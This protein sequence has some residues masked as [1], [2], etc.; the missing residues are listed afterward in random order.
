MSFQSTPSRGYCSHVAS[1][2]TK[3]Q[4]SHEYYYLDSLKKK[5][6]V[7]TLYSNRIQE[8][9]YQKLYLFSVDSCI[10]AE[11]T[12]SVICIIKRYRE[13][14]LLGREKIYKRYYSSAKNDA[15]SAW[16]EKFSIYGQ[17]L[18]LVINYMQS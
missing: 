2:C 7:E 6:N 18:Y 11:G 9:I 10:F 4:K 15:K 17:V 3:L 16:E 14:I 13:N 1:S 5:K 12:L 8:S